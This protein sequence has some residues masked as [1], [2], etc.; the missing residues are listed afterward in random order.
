MNYNH[1]LRKRE[2][3]TFAAILLV[4]ISFGVLLS[5]PDVSAHGGED[6]GEAKPKTETNDKGTVSYTTRVG[7]LEVLLKHDRL[8]PDS[9]NA[10][11]LFV[12]RFETNEGFAN[13]V[14]VLEIESTNGAVTEASVAKATNA[15]SFDVKFPSLPE[16]IYVVRAKLTHGGET[17]TATFS[18]VSVQNA[19]AETSLGGSW[20]QT[21]ITSLLFFVALSL[22]A[23]LIYF[24]AR[25]LK[26][27]PLREETVSA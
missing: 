15:G 6:H 2:L 4:V 10:A 18:G 24:A 11:R 5:A 21:A 1:L 20:T 19:P 27:K 17:D 16:G 8:T 9:A 23:A 12:T 3:F 22:F 7:D 14:P 26:N 13:V 25:T